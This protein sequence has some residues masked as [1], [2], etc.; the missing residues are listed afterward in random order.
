MSA[1]TA[2][3]LRRAAAM[4]RNT[5][6]ME[7]VAVAY[8]RTAELIEKE[9]APDA[10]Q[11]VEGQETDTPEKGRS[12]SDNSAREN[13]AYPMTRAD[14]AA[15]ARSRDRGF[16]LTDDELD[17]L[18]GHVNR[19]PDPNERWAALWDGA[20]RLAH[21]VPEGWDEEISP[22][23]YGRTRDLFLFTSDPEEVGFRGF[24]VAVT[25]T[26][27]SDGCVTREITVEA[28]GVVLTSRQ[29]SFA[30]KQLRIAARALHDALCAAPVAV[31][32]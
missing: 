16:E 26:E 32:R 15:W 21:R 24:E 11:G 23:V 30:A 22:G 4:Y 8:E 1:I 9:S 28:N 7:N 6:G 3:S 5:P 13:L 12:M 27:Q 19:Y 18:A 10:G 31:I 29:A 25:E 17:S 14:V 20:E 2:E